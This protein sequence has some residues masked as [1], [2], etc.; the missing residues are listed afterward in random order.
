MSPRRQG[1]HVDK[2][3]PVDQAARDEITT[4]LRET[5]FV[6]AGAGSGKTREMVERILALVDD[7]VPL[8]RI[9]AI[10]FTNDAA[11]QLREKVRERLEKALLKARSTE[12]DAVAEL[13]IQALGDIDAAP[14]HTI[15]G[16]ARSI[17]ALHPLEA[18]LPPEISLRDDVAANVAFEERWR[19]FLEQLLHDGCGDPAVER[20]L[21][22]GTTLGL[23]PADLRNVASALQ[24]DWDRAC[25]ATF[26]SGSTPQVDITGLLRSVED[27]LQLR[28][29]I[30]PGGEDDKAYVASA[31]IEPVA[32][33][34]LAVRQLQLAAPSREERLFAD[35]EAIRVLRTIALPKIGNLGSPKNWPSPD[36]LASLRTAMKEVNTTAV[37][38]LAMLRAGCLPLL[39][40]TLQ[41]FVRE[42]REDRIA[43]GTLEF[44]DL[45]LLSRDLLASDVAVRTRVAQRYH[46]LLIDEFQD[47]DPIQV[48]IAALVAAG[49]SAQTPS[50]TWF[51][52]PIPPGRLFFVGDPKQSI[53]R[54]RRADV[55]VYE[56]ARTRFGEPPVGRT[57]NLTQN[58]RSVPSVI[59]W[60]NAVFADLLTE[61]PSPPEGVPVVQVPFA[62][63]IA[64]RHENSV[65][66]VAVRL[67]GGPQPDSSADAI[68]ASE[69]SEIASTILRIESEAESGAW[70]VGTKDGPGR[71]PKLSD[72]AI[73]VPARTV[74][75]ALEQALAAARIP[76]RVE[77]QS[78]L[79]DTQEA[80]D[81]LAILG[82][83]DDPTDEVALVAALRS[84][85]FGCTDADLAR[86]A[87][88]RGRWD[89]RRPP[90]DDVDASHPVVLAFSVLNA[91]HEQRWWLDP[92]ALI[93]AV[94]RERRLLHMAFAGRRPRETWRRI[95]FIHE[96]ARAF[97]AAGE[98]SL[99]QFIRYATQQA[100]ENARMDS[101]LVDEEDD[102]AVRILTIHASKGLEFPIVFLAGLGASDNNN[103]SSLLW[104]KEGTPE[105]H[106]GSKDRGIFQ[107]AGY[108]AALERDRTLERLERDRLLYVAATR[109][110]DHLL[111][112]LH[113]KP[114]PKS[115]DH[116]GRHV[117]GQCSAAEC[118][119][120][121]TGRYPD[122]WAPLEPATAQERPSTG[123]PHPTPL[124]IA[125]RD[126]F[127]ASREELLRKMSR[128]PALAATAIAHAAQP[129]E[130]TDEPVDDAAPWKKGRAGTSV[131]RA[132]HATLQSIDLETGHGL[133]AV[134]AAQ[135]LAEGIEARLP[136]VIRFVRGALQSP[137]VRAAVASG[138]YF[139]EVYVGAT[140]EGVLVE[141]FIDLL[142]ETPAG[143]VIVDYKTDTVD[144]EA[145]VD[146]A[147]QRHRLQGAAYAVALAAS[148][149]QPVAGCIF[150][151]V[152]PRVDRS[153]PDLAAAIAEVTAAASRR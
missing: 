101:T 128:Q 20:A 58:F 136:D 13:R 55:E 85:A 73:L 80:R 148:Q 81:M 111:V 100:D 59:A 14:I 132:V 131:G 57:L 72:I 46:C 66:P 96:Q 106:L 19:S 61:P 28:L 17:L 5:I 36:H 121:I 39:L 151:F 99:R 52:L 88:A 56:Q 22:V 152:Q 34:V 125:D 153:I 63:L 143:L 67:F 30:R 70:H 10:T 94:V 89:Y 119:F 102:D 32:S 147:M 91:L 133:E 126:A 1:S 93:D 127:I 149:T 117:R 69:S 129:A 50:A 49:A 45:L 25:E 74:V 64:Y 37:E 135:S 62:S 23:T 48:E 54:F 150:V 9:V 105:V 124:G 79:F 68:R 122:L 138:R 42:Y 18:G 8:S 115:A 51:E 35:E 15:H 86:F 75:P 95:R 53:Y 112:S 2:P 29:Q 118:L 120:H 3:L 87:S 130:S 109:A 77:S 6:E 31:A 108:D 137:A 16:F 92:A 104:S 33:S 116:S 44:N 140:V 114:P 38:I 98:R 113:H 146:A 26:A 40:T 107:T 82:A 71:P 103:L 76:A 41:Q 7:G 12:D 11:A 4:T 144:T 47:T 43:Q 97:S 139:R 84:P 141:G 110:R 24:H 65:S 60:V 145:E 123:E 83:I 78:L 27:V 142:Y 90:P 21:V 134:A